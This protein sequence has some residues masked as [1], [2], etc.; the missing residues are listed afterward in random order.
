MI[1][2]DCQSSLLPT[3]S[4]GRSANSAVSTDI[5]RLLG[6]KTLEQL[7]GLEKQIDSKLQSNEPID[8]EYWE[9]LLR[10]IAVYKAKAELDKIYKSIIQDRVADLR[11][12]QMHEAELAKN[13]L[14][15]VLGSSDSSEPSV[16]EVVSPVVPPICYSQ[17]L[18]PEPHL[19]LSSDDK[20]LDVVM[21]KDFMDR[22][23]RR[24]SSC[25]NP[26]KVKANVS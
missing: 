2:K 7:K 25:S 19:K 21:E 11:R 16:S 5:D 13:K 8:V 9:Q 6:P 12:E 23:V 10:S 26:Q 20:A 15:L 3:V 22:I 18:D 4:Q 14:A 17:M 1:C 24:Q